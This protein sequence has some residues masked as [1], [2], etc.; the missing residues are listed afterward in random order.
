MNTPELV[1][2]QRISPDTGLVECWWTHPFL[3]LMNTWELKEKTW[4]EFGAGLGTA[5]LRNRCKWVDSVES[6]RNWAAKARRYC[7]DNN[8]SNGT[9]YSYRDFDIP[10]GIPEQ[11]S[12]YFNLVPSK[13]YDIISIDGIYRVECIEFAI[14]HFKGRGGILVIDNLNQDYVFISPKAMELIAP[15]EQEIFVQP[16]HVNH[17]GLPWNTRYVKIPA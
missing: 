5:S 13:E 17:E 12:S 2:W 14:K 9:I 4:L 1:E 15:F 16:G 10:D 11:M 6:D 8:L 7:H 3:D